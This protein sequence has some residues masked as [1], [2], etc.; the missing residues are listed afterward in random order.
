MTCCLESLL[1]STKTRPLTFTANPP[2]G[3]DVGQIYEHRKQDIDILGFAQSE[4]ISYGVN[5]HH[6]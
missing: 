1:C 4:P 5:K 3:P 2:A 6:Q